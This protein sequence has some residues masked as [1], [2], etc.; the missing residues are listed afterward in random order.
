MRPTTD[1][2]IADW[3]ASGGWHAED[4]GPQRPGR[5]DFGA[6]DLEIVRE[7]VLARLGV[8]AEEL[9]RACTLG[10]TRTLAERGLRL[11]SWALEHLGV[12]PGD[13]IEIQAA[14]GCIEL[15]R[16]DSFD[17]TPIRR[18][19]REF[20]LSPRLLERLFGIEASRIRR[21]MKGEPTG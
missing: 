21:V 3:L 20:N 9:R 17:P 19:M 11:P 5:L 8:T 13:G 2:A 10:N 12:S 18:R 14:D 7:A 1:P 4:A 15:R 6:T 16:A